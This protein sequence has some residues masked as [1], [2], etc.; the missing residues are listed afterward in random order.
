MRPTGELVELR[1]L[2][3]PLWTAHGLSVPASGGLYRHAV[4]NPCPH[5]LQSNGPGVEVEWPLRPRTFKQEAEPLTADAYVG[6]GTVPTFANALAELTAAVRSCTD[7]GLRTVVTAPSRELREKLVAIDRR[8]VEAASS[9]ISLRC[10]PPA[11][12]QS[13]TQEQEPCWPRLALV[14]L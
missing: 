1:E 13:R 10:S 7:R 4:V 2:V 6:F 11:R 8:L 5:F 14:C 12:L 9:S 3:S